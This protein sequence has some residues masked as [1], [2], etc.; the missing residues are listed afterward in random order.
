MLLSPVTLVRRWFAVHER[1]AARIS[2][3][4]PRRRVRRGW[5]SSLA[6]VYL[7]GEVRRHGRR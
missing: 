2:L 6:R 3:R 4:Y 5:L 7:E 1:L